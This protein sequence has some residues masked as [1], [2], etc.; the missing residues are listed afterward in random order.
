MKFKLG[1]REKIVAGSIVSILFIAGLHLMVFSNKAK[2]YDRIVDDWKKARSDVE[3]LVG[4]AKNP[5]QVDEY[6]KANKRYKK[7]F[8]TIIEGLQLDLPK[9]YLDQSE[10]SKEQRRE[11]CRKLVEKLVTLESDLENT[12]LS[13][14]GEKGWNIPMELPEEIQDR[15]ERL[16][17]VISQINGINRILKVIDNPIVR[18]EKLR[19]YSELLKEIGM[20]EAKIDSL[21]KYGKYVPLINRLCHYRLIIKDK[22]KDFKLTDKELQELLR[23]SYP[24]DFLFKLN[25]QLFAMVDLIKLADENKVEEITEAT[26]NDFTEIYK[27]QEQG[28]VGQESAAATPAAAPVMMEPGLMPGGADPAEPGMRFGP[29][30]RG[31]P[32]EFMGM[33]MGQAQPQEPTGPPKNLIGQGSPILMRFTGSNLNV[34]NYLYTVSHIPRTYEI[35]SLIINTIKD[36]E[37]VEDVYAWINVISLVEGVI[38][39]LE[40]LEEKKEESASGA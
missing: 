1:N 32:M 22:P 17:D 4:Q 21:K 27:Q 2:E 23:I 8:K 14:L 5:R 34:T 20:D 36:R 25:R 7:E 31:G 30:G 6:E 26:L 3:N 38:V 13:F 35:D 37:G 10:E 15:P 29:G 9:Y 24:D 11:V 39:N 12:S 40:S 28:E 33:P 19:Q 18:E 16:W